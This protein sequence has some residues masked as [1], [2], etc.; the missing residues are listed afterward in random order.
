[1]NNPN[2]H[3]LSCSGC[4][5]P[6]CE[7]A[8]LKAP[9]KNLLDEKKEPTIVI[10]YLVAHC[11]YCG[12]KSMPFEVT[13]RYLIG[14]ATKLLNP[15]DENSFYELTRVTPPYDIIGNKLHIK[16]KQWEENEKAM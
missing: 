4:L 14:P 10:D 3:T 9:K 2:I 5:K 8:I 15:D 11:P 6:L 16:V 1:M 13:T 7:V 12:D